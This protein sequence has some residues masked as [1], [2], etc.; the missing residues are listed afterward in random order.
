M[1]LGNST[2]VKVSR[3]YYNS[4][5]ADN[6]YF[7]FW[8]GED[9]HVGIYQGED[10]PIFTACRR[11]VET[12]ASR[13]NLSPQSKVL[14]LGSGY[15]GAAR[16]LT[17]TYG[18]AVTCVNLS[19]IQNERNRLLTKEQGLSHLIKV[20]DGNFETVP[21]TN[22]T[23]DVVWSQDAI[24]HSSDRAQVFKEAARLLA[25]NGHFIFTD[26]M[27]KPDAPKEVLEPV[28]RRIHLDSLGSIEGYT[29]MAKELGFEVVEILDLSQQLTNHYS[30][31]LQALEDN[32]QKAVQISGN[33]YVASMKTGL[34]HWINAGKQGY[35]TWGILHFRKR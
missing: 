21:I 26:P 13:L 1:S 14:D 19:E 23:F 9:I 17:K 33:D 24:L 10:E 28:Y 34:Q 35:L 22:Q 29:E 16:Y 18:C 25:P 5:S 30:R 31:I 8:G 2:V 6:F 27:Q 32:E 11:T 12:I 20:Y 15:G 3:D 7:N 4:Q